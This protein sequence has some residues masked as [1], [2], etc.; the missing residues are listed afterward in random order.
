MSDAAA[1]GAGGP[2]EDLLRRAAR[3]EPLAVDQWLRSER[4]PVYRL[5]LGFLADPAA[6]EDAAQDAMLHL[7]DRLERYEPG[8]PFAAWRN[9]LVLN[10]CRD[11]ARRAQARAR[12]EEAG[13][14]E[15]RE[16]PLPDPAESAAAAETRALVA[17]ALRALPP[18]EREAFVLR[19][20][21]GRDTEEVA[22]AMGVNAGSVRSLLT[23]ARRRLRGLLS[24]S[25]ADAEERHG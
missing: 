12:A 18:R 4:T 25:L 7:L 3:G 1:P 14:A 17:R 8:R 9:A 16:T 19:D 2:P 21:E 23:L 20:L 11:R 10:L 6:A 13:A 15:R 22:A 24:P 5:C